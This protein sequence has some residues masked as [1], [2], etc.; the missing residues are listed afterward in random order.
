MVRLQR[1]DWTQFVKIVH[2]C[3]TFKGETIECI[4]LNNHIENKQKKLQKFY[5]CVTRLHLPKHFNTEEII[6]D[7]RNFKPA[8]PPG[9]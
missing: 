9:K 5:T 6:E 3:F 8:D 2:H 4:P 7:E 1:R